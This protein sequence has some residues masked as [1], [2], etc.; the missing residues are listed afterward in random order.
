LN[1]NTPD[2]SLTWDWVYTNIL[3]PFNL[4]PA[5]AMRA[6]KIGLDEQAVWDNPKGA[7]RIKAVTSASNFR[8]TGYMPITRELSNG[9]RTLVHRWADL[10]IAGKEP[11]GTATKAVHPPAAVLIREAR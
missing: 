2:S 9:M 6:L 1:R 4:C 5:A 7:A 10:V 11:K 3:Q 8:S